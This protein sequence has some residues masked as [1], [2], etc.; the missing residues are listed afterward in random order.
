MVFSAAHL[1]KISI[2]KPNLRFGFQNVHIQSTK[3]KE[4]KKKKIWFWKWKRTTYPKLHRWS[5]RSIKKLSS[6]HF[7][8][9]AFAEFLVHFCAA[10]YWIRLALVSSRF[11]GLCCFFS[12]LLCSHSLAHSLCVRCTCARKTVGDRKRVCPYV[13]SRLPVFTFCWLILL[14]R[15]TELC[16]LCLIPLTEPETFESL[17]IYNIFFCSLLSVHCKWLG[18]FNSVLTNVRDKIFTIQIQSVYMIFTCSN[19]SFGHLLT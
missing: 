15:L 4:K 5:E 1:L 3:K 13:Y 14:T 6:T 2:P 18:L 11:S 9:G 7:L 8:S 19:T 17:R 16:P 12:S 10:A